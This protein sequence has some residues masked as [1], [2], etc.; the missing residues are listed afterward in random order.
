MLAPI[1]LLRNRIPF[2]PWTVLSRIASGRGHI[3]T[4]SPYRINFPYEYF[5]SEFTAAPRF[6]ARAYPCGILGRDIS[7]E[8][9]FVVLGIETSCSCTL[10]AAAIF[11]AKWFLLW[12]F[13]WHWM[14]QCQIG[15][16]SAVAVTIDPGLSLCLRVDVIK[17]RKM[18]EKFSMPFVGVHHSS[19]F[20]C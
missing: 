16:F 9:N 14:K 17:A 13:N 5:S 10:E 6:T 3:A 1:N 11:L 18:A 7:T 20:G 4:S 2:P 19:C 12:L 8:D 15:D